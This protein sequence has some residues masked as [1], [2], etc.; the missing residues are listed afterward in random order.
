MAETYTYTARDAENP[1]NL[2]TITLYPDSV[3]INPT[4]LWDQLGK[5]STTDE[6]AEELR[7]QLANH[8]GPTA[9]KLIE[10]ISGPIHLRDFNVH[11]EGERLQINTWQR[12]NRLRLAPLNLT[13]QRVDNLDAAEAFI[14]EVQRRKQDMGSA[15]T[16][17]GIFDYWAGWMVL[18][19][20]ILTGVLIIL[21]LQRRNK[22]AETQWGG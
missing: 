19:I 11:L 3:K 21:I 4:G 18:A 12:L 16:L 14:A 15:Q 22:G 17:P 20:G 6:K 1:D 10:S 7:R 9:L 2:V 13:F 5:L 8:A